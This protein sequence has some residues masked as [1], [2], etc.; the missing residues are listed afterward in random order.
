MLFSGSPVAILLLTAFMQHA[1]AVDKTTNPALIAK[2]NDAASQL[3][4]L[5]LLPT[6]KDWIFD[7][8][9]QPY[10]TFV[11]GGVVNMNAATFPAAKGNG[12]TCEYI[13]TCSLITT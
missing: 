12:L 13:R 6:D 11:P 1:Q 2:L 5:A 7:F 3:E 9:T 4:R 8:N 10:S